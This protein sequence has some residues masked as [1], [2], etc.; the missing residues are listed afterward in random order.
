MISFI[1]TEIKNTD[2]KACVKIILYTY[3]DYLSNSGCSFK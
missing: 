3:F 1:N 2:L